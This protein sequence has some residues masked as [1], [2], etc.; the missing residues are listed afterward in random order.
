VIKERTLLNDLPKS[1]DAESQRL[2]QDRMRRATWKR[3]VSTF[4]TR[5]KMALAYAASL[6]YNR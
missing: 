3:W 6:L 5:A 4:A 2:A 1:L